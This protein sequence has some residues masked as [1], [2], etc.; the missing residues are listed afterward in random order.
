MPYTAY[1]VAFYEASTGA[2]S[3]VVTRRRKIAGNSK[4]RSAASL[5][6]VKGE[7]SATTKGNIDVKASSHRCHH[8]IHGH[9]DPLL[10]R[11]RLG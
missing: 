4:G 3:C 2:G 5:Q 7:K 8:Q 11:W 6:T 10:W 9:C 1:D